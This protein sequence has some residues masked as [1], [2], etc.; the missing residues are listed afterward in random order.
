MESTGRRYPGP[1]EEL[2]EVLAPD[3]SLH[4]LLA[5]TETLRNDGRLARAGDETGRAAPHTAAGPAGAERRRAAHMIRTIYVARPRIPA[6]VG[7]RH[8]ASRYTLDRK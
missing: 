6:T 4:T 7:S 3:G 8:T 5:F 2:M 1:G